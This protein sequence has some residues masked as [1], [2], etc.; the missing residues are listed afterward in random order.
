MLFA[1]KTENNLETA[2]TEKLAF[3]CV[4]CNSLQVKRDDAKLERTECK[5]NTPPWSLVSIE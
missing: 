3:V 2:H 1:S 5:S 4:C